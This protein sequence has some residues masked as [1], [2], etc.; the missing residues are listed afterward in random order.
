MMKTTICIVED[1]E[2]CEP[3]VRLLLTSL[4]KHCPESVVNLFYRGAKDKFLD[5]ASK[6]PQVHVHADR[7]ESG[8]GWNIK[9]QAILHLMDEGFDEVIW[10]DSDVIVARDFTPLFARLGGDT[11]VATEDGLG[12]EHSD[13]NSFRARLWG[14]PVGRA[15]P[16]GLNSGVLR[17]TRQHLSLIKRWWDLLQSGAYK[18]SQKREWTQRPIHMLGDQ[19]VL[20]ALLTSQEFSEI[21][22]FLLRRGQHILQFNGVYG[23]TSAERLMNLL[24]RG[25][26]FIH[27]FAGKPWSDRWSVSLTAD[28][29]EY[30]KKVYLDL[31]P[32]TLLA[33]QFKGDIACDT[34]WMEAHYVPSRILRALGMGSPALAGLP[35][36]AFMDLARLVTRPGGANM[37]DPKC[38]RDL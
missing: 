14:F 27:S 8:H 24:G 20:T 25:P 21:P 37:N 9:P 12:R 7:L 28:P 33:R 23:Y 19:D 10:I 2:R 30:I 35:I 13:L 34:E 5:W 16:F 22:L 31:S 15:L 18:E 4:V 26:F 11:F 1:R 6:W 32:Y 36:A 3:S 29:R 17:V 38:A